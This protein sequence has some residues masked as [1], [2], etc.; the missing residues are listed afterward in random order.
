MK[1][2]KHICRILVGLLFIYSGFVK[3]IDPLGSNYKF[4]E[5]FHA[6]QMDWLAGT[7]LFFSF[8]L[9]LSEFMIGFCLVFNLFIR[10]I[11][12]GA[13]LFMSFLTPLT[14]ILAIKNPVSD[15]GCFGDALIL[16]NWETFWKNFIFLLITLVVFYTKETFKKTFNLLEQITLFICALFF[17]IYLTS[18]CYRH[19]PI[20]DFRPYAIGKN[21]QEGM[22]I[23]DGAPQDEYE[24]TL[25]YKNKQTGEIKTFNEQNYP[26]QDTLNWEFV[27]SSEKLIKSGVHPEIQDFIIEHPEQGTI[28]QELL[29]DPTYTFLAIAYNIHHTTPKYQEQLNQLAAYAANHGYRFY[30]LT[31]S[32]VEEVQVYK[33]TYQ[34][35]YDFYFM[36]ETQLKTI[37]R[38]NPGL[39]LLRQGTILNKW[40]GRDFPKPDELKEK[41]LTAYCINKQQERTDKLII[42]IFILGFAICILFFLFQKHKVKHFRS[43]R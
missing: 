40:A 11:S 26:W 10:W 17:M 31:A 34:V 32:N 42:W 5:Y 2:F 15:C 4:I 38:S 8:F 36:D 14:L 18:Y 7:A 6:F 24:I 27:N 30:G 3:G 41:E 43:I 29:E 35:N 21:I 37:I 20:L 28:T 16:T 13:L 12:W 25:E 1:L 33:T 23:P 22:A 19:L 9:S 39:V